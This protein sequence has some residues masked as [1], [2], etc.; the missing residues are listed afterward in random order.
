MLCQPSISPCPQYSLLLESVKPEIMESFWC[1][2]KNSIIDMRNGKK[3]LL[4]LT[5]C[6]KSECDMWRDGEC[7]H[8]HQAGK[9]DYFFFSFSGSIQ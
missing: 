8:I 1:T 5:P 6:R 4:A 7:S 3:L 2:Q 9:Q